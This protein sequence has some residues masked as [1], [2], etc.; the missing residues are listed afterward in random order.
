MLVSGDK[1]PLA[2][3]APCQ[4]PCACLPV[5]LCSVDL[6][7]DS[8]GD[9]RNGNMFSWS[10]PSNSGCKDGDNKLLLCLE[11]SKQSRGSALSRSLTLV[12]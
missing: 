2:M 4:V 8:M 6:L 12:R 3:F 7:E 9:T 5:L 10:D 1:G 11:R